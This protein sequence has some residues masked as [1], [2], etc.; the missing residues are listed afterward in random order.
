M[1]NSVIVTASCIF[2]IELVERVACEQGNEYRNSE[3]DCNSVEDTCFDGT[4]VLRNHRESGENLYN[5]EK[6]IHKG[7]K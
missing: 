6:Q 3:D 4:F 2:F 1:R 7:G 5:S